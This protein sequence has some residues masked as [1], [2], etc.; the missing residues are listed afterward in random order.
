MR[1]I[2]L[3]LAIPTY[4]GG[5][6]LVE[7]IESCRSINLSD[8]EFEVLIVNNCSNDGSIEIVQE[9]F[10]D[11]KPIRVVENDKNY[12][13]IGNWNRCIEVAR[14]EFMLFLFA[15]DLL[16]KDNHIAEVTSLIKQR[17]DCSLVNMP[18]IISDYNMTQKSL[19]PQFFARTP[20]YGYFSCNGHI[21]NVVES[22]KLPFVPLQS[23]IVR[24]SVIID[25][26]IQFD[27][28]LPI[29]SDGVFLTQLAVSTGIVGFYEK[30][31]VIWR[32]DAPNRLHGHIK[33]NEHNQ[34]LIESFSVINGLIGNKINL[35][36]AFA[37]SKGLEYI[38]SSI[39]GIKSKHDAN[40]SRRFV[41]NWW[42]SLKGYNVNIA[43]FVLL[44]IWEIIKWPI[45]IKTLIKL[46]SS[47]I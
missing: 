20:G 41:V 21:K 14:G 1:S 12:G 17:E 16:D 4:N 39:I 10:A 19:S 2:T 29:T 8:D 28:K 35:A 23:N 42:Q 36:K 32:H 6:P 45:K 34:Q 46:L 44:S 38:V 33:L 13:R 15:N 27:S 5:E 25:Q 43:V 11:F 9:Q 22:G 26:K 40:T 30:S 7:A 37:K 24:R 31:S 3:S 47:R 18:W